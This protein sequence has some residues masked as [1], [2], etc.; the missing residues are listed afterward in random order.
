MEIE[1]SKLYLDIDEAVKEDKRY[2]FL[3][4]GSRSGKSY[5]IITYL[6][7][8]ALQNKDTTITIVRDTLVSIRNS[9]L[10]DFQEVMNKMGF[11]N[12]E[13][14]N[15][16]EVIYKFDNGSLIRFLGADDNSGKLRGMRQDVVFI[17]EITSVSQEAFVQLDIRTTGFIIADY[18]PSAP[19]DWFVYD[20]ETKPESKLIISTYKSNP[21]LEE[22]IIKSIEGLKDIDPEMY[23]VYALGKKI[24]PRETIFIN[25]EVVDEPPRY[26]KVLG[27]GLDWGYSDDPTACVF[28]IINEVDN[29]IYLK[30]MFYDKG[31]TTDDI[32]F[33]LQE[34]GIRKEFDLICDSSEP[35]MID[36]VRAG[37]WKK[38]KGVKKEA[39]SVLFGITEMKKFKLQIDKSSTNLIE[40]LKNYKWHKDRSG[41]ITS[42]PVGHKGDHLIDSARYLITEM[43]LKPKTKYSFV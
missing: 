8:Y 32:L 14:F 18:N 4:G 15:K 1:V 40:E 2:I 11:Y 35:R 16:T 23:E 13:Q 19:E 38:A 39:G 24:K 34:N 17:N 9:I 5:Q 12:P 27:F 21:F 3:R 37:G 30:E 36:A 26:S 31:L 29:I 6:I 20:F 22:R 25:W 42:K 28:G 43:A 33:K 7:L 10:I 41:N